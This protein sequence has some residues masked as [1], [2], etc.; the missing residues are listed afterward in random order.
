MIAA[1]RCFQ[2][3][4]TAKL[5]CQFG[6]RGRKPATN[7]S[8]IVSVFRENTIQRPD[9]A[10]NCGQTILQVT[11]TL[12]FFVAARRYMGPRPSP[13]TTRKRVLLAG[14]DPG[15]VVQFEPRAGS[16]RAEW[17]VSEGAVSQPPS[18]VGGRLGGF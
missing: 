16:R 15:R 13:G 7:V 6:K 17:E 12:S 10:S 5:C 9:Y 14:R 4:R 8:E 3:L 11:L 2:Y 1:K 18:Q